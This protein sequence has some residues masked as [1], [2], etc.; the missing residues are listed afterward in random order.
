[1]RYV[2]RTPFSIPILQDIDERRPLAIERTFALA[3]AI[4]FG[5]LFG[6]VH[7]EAKNEERVWLVSHLEEELLGITIWVA[8]EKGFAFGVAQASWTT[9]DGSTIAHHLP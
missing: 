6:E 5:G 7:A 9:T 8:I 1:M 3:V 4:V 2:Q